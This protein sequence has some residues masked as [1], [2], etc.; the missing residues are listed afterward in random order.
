M[1]EV[2]VEVV[3]VEDTIVVDVNSNVVDDV[4]D[5]VMLE[6]EVEVV[7]VEDAIV[8]DVD[9]KV[10]VDVVVGVGQAIISA[11]TAATP[12]TINA[13]NANAINFS[14]SIV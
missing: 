5:I 4:V 13:I 9:P 11:S 12:T 10:M 8:V 3:D 2:E 6:V 14:L 1:L 7:D